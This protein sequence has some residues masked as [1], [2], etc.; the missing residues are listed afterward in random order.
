M[1]APLRIRKNLSRFTHLWWLKMA[2]WRVKNGVENGVFV[3]RNGAKSGALSRKNE[4]DFVDF[5][6]GF[7]EFSPLE[8][9][10]FIPP[11]LAKKNRLLAQKIFNLSYSVE[12]FFGSICSVVWCEIVSV[13]R[14]AK[15]SPRW[16]IE[17]LIETAS[18][19]TS[20]TKITLKFA[21][22]R[23]MRTAAM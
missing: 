23:R 18:H 11:N 2:V 7:V 12:L 15:R 9:E 16:M 17:P 5:F 6:A 8:M 19:R 14:S 10:W 22:R 21:L 1:G 20:A 13:S 4:W 3:L